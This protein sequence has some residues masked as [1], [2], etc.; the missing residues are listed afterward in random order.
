MTK[1]NKKS[2][3]NDTAMLFGFKECFVDI[4]P[5]SRT[6]ML[7]LRSSNQYIDATEKKSLYGVTSVQLRLSKDGIDAYEINLTMEGL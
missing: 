5:F 4:L 3:L 2:P 1:L 6:G 7:P